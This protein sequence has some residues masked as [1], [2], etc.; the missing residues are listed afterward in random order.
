[1]AGESDGQSAILMYIR[2][3]RGAFFAQRGTIIIAVAAAYVLAFPAVT[4]EVYRVLADDAYD[5]TNLQTRVIVARGI[6]WLPILFAYV[7]LALASLTIWYA[8][9]DVAGQVHGPAFTEPSLKGFLLRW[10]PVLFAV[11]LPLAT[12]WGMFQ[13]SLDAQLI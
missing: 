2:Q 12:A 10:L 6:T 4:H 3:I 8:G 13:A 5:L 1:M 11:L 9:R 7:T